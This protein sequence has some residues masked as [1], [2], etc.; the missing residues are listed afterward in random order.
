MCRPSARSTARSTARAP[1][2]SACGDLLVP[3]IGEDAILA[4]LEQRVERLLAR[5]TQ[6]LVQRFLERH[7]HR[8]V[9]AVRTAE[10][11]VDD[12]VDEPELLQTHRGDA[13]RLRGFRRVLGR[14]PE[15]RR[16]TLG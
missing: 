9:S 7:Q 14:F 1:A 8:A 16:A 4:G 6:C 5:L 15:D 10:R 12:L 11:L 13:E 3:A 2:A